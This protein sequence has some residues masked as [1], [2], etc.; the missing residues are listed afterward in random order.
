MF[1]RATTNFQL[2][3]SELVSSS[4][5]P[6]PSTPVLCFTCCSC[7]DQPIEP[8]RCRFFLT[9]AL[10]YIISYYYLIL[11]LVVFCFV[12]L[13][14]WLENKVLSSYFTK[15][16]WGYTPGPHLELLGKCYFYYISNK[17]TLF[18]YFGGFNLAIFYCPIQRLEILCRC[19]VLER[20]LLLYYEHVLVTVQPV[21]VIV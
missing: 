7:T 10:F 20:T 1:L 9:G 4:V 17:N 8:V 16:S 21:C 18:L 13:F 6:R 3:F 12:L 2:F 19:L 11:M 5:L 14:K 15:C